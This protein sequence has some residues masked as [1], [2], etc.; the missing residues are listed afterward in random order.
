[1][2][3]RLDAMKQADAETP[4]SVRAIMGIQK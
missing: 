2:P 1:M 4:T 3:D